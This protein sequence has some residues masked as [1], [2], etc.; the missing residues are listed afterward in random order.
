MPGKPKEMSQVKQILQLR[1]QGRG[2]KFISKTLGI[3]RKAVK[4]YFERAEAT[5]LSIDELLQLDCPVLEKKLLAGNPAYKDK[6]Y[7]TLKSELDYYAKEL[8]RTGVTI[9]LLWQEYKERHPDGYSRS[10]FYHHLNQHQKASNPSMVLEHKAGEKLF[11]DFAGDKLHYVDT[12][13]GEVIG[14]N[15]FVASLPYS[16]YSFA[17]AVKSQTTEDFLYA[18]ECCLEDFGG[19]PD[20]LVPDNLKAAIVKADRYEPEVNRALE[21][22]A[23]HY[24]FA[25]LPARVRKPKD[26]ALVENQVKIIY[27]RV[28]AKLRNDQFHSLDAL[29]KAIKQKIKLHNQTRM[30]AKPWSREEKFLA[31]EKQLLKPLPPNRF[32]MKYYSTLKVQKN[33]HVYLGTDKHYYSVPYEH[34]GK[35]AKVIYTRNMV[36][37]YV[38]GE[39]VA[40][41][42][43]DY[44]QG[45]YTTEK[46]HLCSAHQRYKDRSPEYY[47]KRAHGRCRELGLYVEAIFGQPRYPEQLYKT[48]EGLLSLEKKEPDKKRFKKACEIATENKIYSYKR[49]RKILE[50]NANFIDD[51][52]HNRQKNPPEGLPGHDNIRGKNYYQNIV[53]KAKQL[54]LKLFML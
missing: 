35:G 22:F 2:S 44:R 21:D 54:S 8:H 9:L 45:N 26:K 7:D 38:D 10:Q 33:N 34:I 32:E 19:V 51:E 47:K 49:F 41:H 48:C 20:V 27:S 36:H 28:Y 23:N 12:S 1:K 37:I 11:V 4:D 3:S 46:S 25:V 24:G 6:R 13:T 40:V 42:Q 16:D 15:V 17:M 52:M 50:N 43:R 14:C 31:E 5:K 18:L 29:N 39:Q 30:Q 53:D